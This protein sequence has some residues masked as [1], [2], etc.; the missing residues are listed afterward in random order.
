MSSTP[1]RRV[2]IVGGPAPLIT[3]AVAS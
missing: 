3:P 1:P 2:T